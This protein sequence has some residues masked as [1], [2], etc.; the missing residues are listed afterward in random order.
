MVGEAGRGEGGFRGFLGPLWPALLQTVLVVGTPPLSLRL[1]FSQ[2]PLHT[3][4]RGEKRW[5]VLLHGGH[6]SHNDGT[7]FQ[8]FLSFFV[9]FF[10]FF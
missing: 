10:F 2:S 7:F 8:F 4:W 1:P 3:V 6:T 9:F 5:T